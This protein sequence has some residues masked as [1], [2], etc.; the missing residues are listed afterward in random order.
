MHTLSGALGPQGQDLV[1]TSQLALEDQGGEILGHPVELQIEDSACSGEGG[2]TAVLKITADPQVVAIA[3]PTC[4]GAAASAMKI[5]SEAGLVMVSGSASAPSLTS[6]GGEPG[7][8]WLP[9]FYRTAQN[10]AMVG[11]AAA[12][13]AFEELGLTRAATIDDGDPY[14]QG[15][16]VTFQ[17]AFTGL[18]GETVLAS[19]VNRGDTDMRPVLEAVAAS[20]AELLFLPVFRN[21]GDYLVLQAR[22]TPGLE[23]ITLM[24]A[25]GLFFDAFI[26]TVGEAGIGM[27]FNAPT[28]PEGPAFERF[29]AAYENRYDAPP[30][31]TPYH[32]QTYDAVSLLLHTIKSVAVQNADGTLH[33]GRQALRDALD[34]TDKYQ[35]MTGSLTCDEYGDCGAVR[36]RTMRLED[37]AAGLE[38]LAANVVY[39]YPP[40]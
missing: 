15:L 13:F 29:Y 33:I 21:E 22:E 18:G 39:T 34:A 2:T 11:R 5:A 26:E 6:V 9:G 24:T 35:G 28:A 12:T 36:L 23:D 32:G 3:G 4:S 1:Q 20:G 16:S 8:N 25:E 30:T 40:R 10:D 37:P 17:Q 38:G 19:A 27:Y 14:T 7:A 31:N